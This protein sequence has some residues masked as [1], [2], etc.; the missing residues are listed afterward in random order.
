LELIP[1]SVGD[2]TSIEN[3]QYFVDSGDIKT[4]D[5][6]IKFFSAPAT[7]RKVERRLDSSNQRPRLRRRYSVHRGELTNDVIKTT[8][9]YSDL[10]YSQITDYHGSFT[11]DEE[12]LRIVMAMARGKALMR[13]LNGYIGK[14][15]PRVFGLYSDLIYG[16]MR[17]FNKLIPE[18]ETDMNFVIA[19]ARGKVLRP[20]KE[21]KVVKRSM[22]RKS[23]IRRSISYTYKKEDRIKMEFAKDAMALAF[24]ERSD[25][26]IKNSPPHSRPRRFTSW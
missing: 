14:K 24:S 3:S 23:K 11:A 12:E 8:F 19:V 22:R 15:Y 5:T 4:P 6:K 21:M 18:D 25:C 17:D 10:L 2:E 1:S 16:E 20:E 26:L 7:R 9:N 13:K